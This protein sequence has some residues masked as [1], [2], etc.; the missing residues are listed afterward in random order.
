MV[1]A[2]L[3]LLRDQVYSAAV[4][5]QVY[6]QISKFT[7][8]PLNKPRVDTQSTGHIEKYTEVKL[9]TLCMFYI[10]KIDFFFGFNLNLE[11]LV[12]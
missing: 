5:I 4:L 8:S 9:R 11:I 3:Q 1:V 10:L 6:N 12:S 2:V 7:F